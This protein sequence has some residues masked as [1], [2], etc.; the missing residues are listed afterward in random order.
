MTEGSGVDLV[1]D[2]PG[3]WLFEESVRALAPGGRVVVVGFAA[4]GIPSIKVNRLL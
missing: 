4:G 3:D 2:P 1:L